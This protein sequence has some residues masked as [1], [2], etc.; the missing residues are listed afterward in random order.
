MAKM[1]AA[2]AGLFKVAIGWLV[3]D[4]AKVAEK[5]GAKK[6]ALSFARRSGRSLRNGLSKGWNK[7]KPFLKRTC[8]GDPVDVVT[9]EVALRQVDVDLPGVLPL[10]LE[11]TH[12]SS[13]REGAV[14]GPSWASTLGQRLEVDAAGVCFASAD[15]MI[16]T[17]PLP[18]VPGVAVFP[19]HGPRRP[20]TVTSSGAYE[21][22]DRERGHTLHFAAPDETYEAGSALAAI[23]DRNGNRIDLVYDE[24]GSLVEVRHSGGYRIGVASDDGG[25]IAELRLLTGEHNGHAGDIVLLRFGYDDAGNLAEVVNSSGRPLRYDYD[26]DH[27]LA[28]WTDRNGHWYRYSYDELGRCVLAQESEGFLD[29]TFEYSDQVT[30]VTD[31]LGHRTTYHFN[32]LGQITEEIDA[33]G[34]AT[35]SEWDRHDRLVSHIDSLGRVTGYAYDEHGDLVAVARPDGSRVTIAYNG[36]GLPVEFTE[37]DG[38][39]WRQSRDERG[40]VIA[41][42]DPL[43]HT[44]RYGYDERGHLVAVTDQL[45]NTTTVR[46]NPAGLPVAVTDPLG[47]TTHNEH[48]AHGRVIQIVD[49]AGSLTSMTWTVE[50]EPL[51]RTLPSGATERWEHDAEGNLVEYVDALGRST[52]YEA[53]HFDLRSA[54]IGPDGGRLQFGYDTELRLISVTNPAGLTWRYD[55]DP[56]GNLIREIDFNDREVRYGYDAAGQ[57]TERTSATGETIVFVRDARGNA[58]EERNGQAVATFA[59]DLAGHLVRATNPDADVRFRRDALGQVVAEI[60]NGR[61]IAFGYDAAGRRLRRRTPSGAESAWHYDAADRAVA[62][63]I[64][65]QTL[66]FAYDPAG[67]EIRRHIGAGAVLDQRWDTDDQLAAQTLWGAPAGTG[68]GRPGPRRLQHRTYSYRADGSVAGIADQTFGDRRYD[69]DRAGRVTAVSA[70]GWTERYAYDLTGNVTGATWPSAP[71][72]DADAI[73]DREYAGTLIRR[74]GAVRYEHDADGR[75][76][77]RQHKRLSGKPLTWRFSWDAAD[78]LTAVRTPEGSI[79]IYRYDALGRRVAKQRLT[80]D[81]AVAEQYDFTWDGTV[82]AEQAHWTGAV[83]DGPTV[84]VTTWEYEPGGFRPLSQTERTP[85]R[86]ASQ[87]WIDERFSAIVTDFAGAPTELVDAVGTLRWTSRASLWG[88]REA[89]S[90]CALRFPGQY[91][92]PESGLSYN[93]HRYYSPADGRYLSTDPAGID[94]G[95]NPHAYVPNPLLWIDPL[96]LKCTQAEM[97]AMMR[98]QKIAPDLL[99]KGV[100]FN[101]GNVELKVLP[102]GRG[103]VVLKSVFSRHLNTPE[104]TAAL[105]KGYGALEYPE[106]RKWLT[107]HA[108]AGLQM[109]SESKVQK[110]T[111]KGR[112]FKGLLKALGGM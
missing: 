77:L 38:A 34:H 86:D 88:S 108:R 82:L 6:A 20:L 37:A 1:G 52:R 22:V 26:A 107:G 95:L 105:K 80:T 91:F 106:F 96:G 81:G 57:L 27:R 17:Y 66:G 32:E 49:P 85:L 48:D 36:L 7:A 21:L 59:Y 2:G 70:Q 51:T 100:H 23:S 47:N 64:T 61:E 79:W 29:A 28:G 78:R 30:V 58:L 109:A 13:Y 44:T 12:I 90:S 89:D 8:K 46:N 83:H 42:A 56:A 15:G 87:H 50:G 18:A 74:A 35:R 73:G 69:V 94:G 41:A 45:G 62:L 11:R 104:L 112:E 98:S 101:V 24:A 43:G 110:L 97:R 102:T 103:D 4:V 14:F 55:Y 92:D 10:V 71:T 3:K 76:V 72:P 5:G 31:S 99:G 53:T 67:R 39:T 40:N 33:L 25:R 16:L 93:Y 60:C 63:N 84:R 68:P 65:D 19:E 111:G 75:V 54:E 9:G